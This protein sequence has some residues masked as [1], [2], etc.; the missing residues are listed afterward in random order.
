MCLIT[1]NFGGSVNG[2]VFRVSEVDQIHTVFLAVNSPL[3][4]SE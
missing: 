4:P 1:V 2:R 3:L